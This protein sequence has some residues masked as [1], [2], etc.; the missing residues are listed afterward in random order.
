MNNNETVEIAHYP[1]MSGRGEY[2]YT[3]K[4]FWFV[5]RA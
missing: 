5:G 1:Y 2:K 3:K 4:I